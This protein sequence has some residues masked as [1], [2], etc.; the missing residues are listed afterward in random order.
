MPRN[1]PIQILRTTR[2]NL[3]TQASASGLLAGE[4]YLVTDERCLAVGTG[5]DAYALAG[6]PTIDQIAGINPTLDLDFVNQVYRHYSPAT[7]LREK[8]LSDIVTFTRASSATYFDAKGMMQ[9][10]ASDAPRIDFDPETGE[11]KGLLVEESRTNLLTYS[12]QFDNA[13]WTKTRTTIE[14]NAAIAP[15]GTLTADKLVESSELGAHYVS[16]SRSFTSGTSYCLSFF[17]K[18]AERTIFMLS[19]PTGIFPS[20]IT[21]VFD[22]SSG[23]IVSQG[24]SITDAEIQ[25]LNG[26]FRCSIVS[27][28]SASGSGILS[29]WLMND[30]VSSY[31]GDGTSGLYLWG[32]QLEVGSFPTSYIKT[33]AATV[34]RAA[35]VAVVSGTPFTDYHHTLGTLF[36]QYKTG[37]WKHVVSPAIASLNLVQDIVTAAQMNDSIRRV[38]FFPRELPT[39]AIN[40]IKAN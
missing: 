26:W 4:P 13:V 25:Q 32:A 30:V 23:T 18:A 35:D 22:L 24:A 10:A 12:E 33:E 15:D 21:A 5:T 14:T 3:D 27:T 7:G 34:T 11:C 29:A 9:T 8:D 17:V 19:F 1:V 39:A 38:V 40:Q 6:K 16:Q 37:G 20:G 2:A 28:T 36:A 31:T